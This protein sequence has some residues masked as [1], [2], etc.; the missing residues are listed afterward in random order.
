MGE[1]AFWYVRWRYGVDMLR[2]RPVDAIQQSAVPV[3]LIH[4]AED[5]AIRVTHARELHAVSGCDYWE[6]PRAGHTE[7]FRV[8]AHEYERRV[9][10]C[11]AGEATSPTTGNRPE[12]RRPATSLQ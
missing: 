12:A 8:A 7:P 5:R 6:V 9:V 1:L 2:A 4:G 3:L 11:L 10:A